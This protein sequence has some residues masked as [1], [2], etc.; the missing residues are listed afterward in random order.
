MTSWR[1]RF[2]SGPLF[3]QVQAAMPS[4]SETESQALK[5]GDVW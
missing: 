1:Q 5:P 2:I 4:I 3:K